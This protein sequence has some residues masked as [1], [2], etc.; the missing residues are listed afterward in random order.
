[1]VKCKFKVVGTIKI[2]GH[3]LAPFNFA[4]GPCISSQAVVL[5]KFRLISSLEKIAFSWNY[6]SGLGIK[7]AFPREK[8]CFRPRNAGLQKM[9]GLRTVFPCVPTHF[10]P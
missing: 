7:H 8:R 2:T 5:N 4:A 1:M 10:N 9:A 6:L 3:L